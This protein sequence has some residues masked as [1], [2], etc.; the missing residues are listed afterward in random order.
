VLEEPGS[1][2][3]DLRLL[4][5]PGDG[6]NQVADN[7]EAFVWTRHDHA[8]RGLGSCMFCEDVNSG[9]AAAKTPLDT[10]FQGVGLR[11]G[12]GELHPEFRRRSSGCAGGEAS[13]YRLLLPIHLPVQAT[14]PPKQLY[15]SSLSPPARTRAP[16]LSLWRAVTSALWPGASP[17][18]RLQSPGCRC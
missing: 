9:R 6:V 13:T 2:C 18:P 4:G 7:E 11:G 15:V 16:F 5:V 17:R 1:R 8:C 3:T 12:M 14:P 10:C